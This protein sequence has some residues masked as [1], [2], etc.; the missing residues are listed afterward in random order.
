MTTQ[1]FKFCANRYG[2][3]DIIPA[4]STL[5]GSAVALAS[6]KSEEMARLIASAPELLALA[7]EMESYLELKLD[8]WRRVDKLPENHAIVDTA[9]RYLAQC[10]S[11][12]AK[13]KGTP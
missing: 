13:A 4:D 9:V 3:F 1:P 6:A 2:S 11:A 8:G 7:Q 12:I 5:T 10:R